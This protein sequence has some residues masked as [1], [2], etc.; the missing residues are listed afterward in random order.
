[1]GTLVVLLLVG[2]VALLL[3]NPSEPGTQIVYMPVAVERPRQGIGCVPVLL[4]I[5]L[6]FLAL[7]L[8]TGNDGM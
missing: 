2:L 7:S 5:V 6:I 4:I 8:L 1:M 3:L